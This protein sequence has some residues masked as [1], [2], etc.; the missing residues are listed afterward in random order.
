[1]FHVWTDRPDVTVVNVQTEWMREAILYFLSRNRPVVIPAFHLR[2]EDKAQRLLDQ[3]PFWM[4][5][6][7]LIM[8]PP[9]AAV[10]TMPPE[11]RG[12]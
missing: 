11:P 6:L 9:N 1:M 7:G 2:D 4:S 8:V 3:A 12:K 10:I 5:D